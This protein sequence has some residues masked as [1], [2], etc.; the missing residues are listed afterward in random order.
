[1]RKKIVALLSMC[2]V[3]AASIGG[4]SNTAEGTSF[5]EKDVTISFMA[6][7]E[8]IQEAEMQLAEKFTEE[9]GIKV[10]YQILP[11]DQYLNLLATKLYTGESTDIFAAQSGKFDIVAQFNVEKNAVDLS[12]ESWAANVEELAAAELMVDGKLYGQPIQDVSAIWAVGYNK[13]IFAGLNLEVPTDYAS[14]M[15]ICQ[16]MKDSGVI[17][18]YEAVSDGWHHTLWFLETCIAAEEAEP[19]LAEK[20]NSNEEV[21]AGNETM[22]K[23]LRQMKEMV[24]KG[25]W[26]DDYMSN[27]YADTAEKIAVG[28]YAMS[29]VNQGFGEEVEAVGK[30][31]KKEDIGYFVIPLADNQVK[32]VNP[33][34][35]SRFIFSG[36][37]HQEEA[38]QFLAYLASEESLKYMT[39]NVPKFNKLPYKNAPDTYEGSVEE[40]Y[41]AYPDESTVYQTA[42]RYVNPQWNEIG[43]NLS[44]MLLG[45]IEP[46]DVLE[47]IDNLREKQAQAVSDKAWDKLKKVGKDSLKD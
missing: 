26:G 38:K 20:L 6:S 45:D 17:P 42:V 36:S 5:T 24:D 44:A 43:V 9:T 32:N 3:M 25:Y 8:W 40:L 27:E 22:A 7:Q 34:G 16:T 31:L 4:C 30:G 11:S 12:G 21:F 13:K 33:A 41:N 37:R 10:D 19:G 28:D 18:I 39:E 14:F 2:A 1:M 15:D 35:P 47:S 46:K 29:I 23:I